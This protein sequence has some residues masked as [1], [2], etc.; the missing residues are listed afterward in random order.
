MHQ[1]HRNMSGSCHMPPT[2]AM[3]VLRRVGSIL[4]FLATFHVGE[5][6]GK[7]GRKGGGS[8]GDI[9]DAISSLDLPPSLTAVFAITIIVAV[10][11]LYQLGRAAARFKKPV[12]PEGSPILP[13]QVGKL[14][15]ILLFSYLFIF[16]VWN[17][18]Y[19]VYIAIFYGNGSGF[20]SEGFI[21]GM[22]FVGQLADV[23]FF[24]MIFSIIAYRQRI[25]LHP[26][27]SLFNLVSFLQGWVL[28]TMF[29]LGI[30]Q[31]ALAGVSMNDSG[32]GY[33]IAINNISIASQVFYF[34]ACIAVAASAIMAYLRLKK[35]EIQD[36]VRATFFMG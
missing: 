12:L 11:T 10:L 19:A 33:I 34:I 30:A 35:S 29:I 24:S 27:E 36:V 21:P 23:L 22:W 20:L 13:Y 25:Q 32:V 31:D 18:L 8:A 4:L 7:G 3:S 28:G 26:T 1:F 16:L 9:G 14:F 6:V 2:A 5:V 17:V 15:P